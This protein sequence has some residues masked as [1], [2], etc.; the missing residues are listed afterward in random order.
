ME[1]ESPKPPSTPTGA[2][3]LSYASQDTDVAQRI[4]TALRGAGIEV[5]FDQSEL[6]GGDAWDRKIREQIHDCR[7]F[8]PVISANSERRDEGYF[9]REWSLAVERTRDMAYKRAFLVPVVIDGTPERG[10]SVPEKFHELQW[11]RLPNGETTPAFI[12][13]LQRL[14]S[15]EAPSA[16]TATPAS[17]A[18]R[19]THPPG[20]SAPSSRRFKAGAWVTGAVLAAALAYIAIDRLL[21][22]RHSPLNAPPAV[23]STQMAP[24]APA[25]AAA[26]NPPTHSLAVLP[27]V[28]MSGDPGQ[29]YF[30]DGL[31][32]ELLNSLSRISELHVAART[33]AFSFKGKDT[34][35]GT[36]ARKLNVGA[37]LEGSVR[38]SAHTV[39]VTTQLVDAVSGF[40]LWSQVYDRSLV[41]SSDAAPKIEIG[42][43]HN[44]AALDE[45]LRGRKG[46]HDATNADDWPPVVAAYDAAIRLDPNFALAFA[47]RSAA[48]SSSA[49]GASGAAFVEQS[50]L[51]EADA[52]RAIELAP[53][54]ADGHLALGYHFRLLLDFHQMSAE[55]S[56]ALA[57]APGNAL[58]LEVTGNFASLMGQH[59]V[60][61]SAARRAVELDPLNDEA[62]AA[63]GDVL[64][65]ARHYR[66]AIDAYAHALTLNPRD[67]R[68]QVFTG[69]SQYSLGDFQ[70]ARA[71]C[72]TGRRWPFS[73]VCIAVTDDKLGGHADAAAALEKLRSFRGEGAAYQ[74]VGIYAQWGQTGKALEWLDTALRIRDVGLANLKVDPLLDPLRNEPRFEA[75]MREL[76]FPD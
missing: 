13:R 9:R 45:F 59:D 47:A 27:F 33:S 5:W 75:V 18:P 68:S 10:A 17:T 16:R 2:V 54:L 4:C 11:T 65:F 31:T 21:I 62:Y 25:T 24:S 76:K 12:E 53:E 48:H 20:R 29:E 69:L 14:L 74:Y 52:R 8:I 23:P 35:I 51:A 38:R 36:I 70:G 57:L 58:V 40:H 44:A 37:V 71:S 19:T 1:G 34:D 60:A 22:S 72:E 55:S 30:S 39:R 15:P 28:N 41:L 56:Q 6:R 43:T 46:Q 61:V 67:A 50:R 49:G 32:E 64:R 63:L 26:F 3:F 66:E 7:L 73:L 42:G